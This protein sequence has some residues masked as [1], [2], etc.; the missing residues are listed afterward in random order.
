[1]RWAFLFYKKVFE[2]N[3]FKL[4]ENDFVVDDKK[5]GGNALYIKKDRFLMHTSFLFDF[6][7]EKINKYL[8]NPKKAPTYRNNRGHRDFITKLR[9][10]ISKELFLEKLKKTIRERIHFGKNNTSKK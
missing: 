4:I 9:P 10:F 7:I 3:D 6:D 2:M 5:I 1:M 8:L